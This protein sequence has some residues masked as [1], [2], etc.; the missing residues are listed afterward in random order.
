MVIFAAAS[1]EGEYL[2]S[3]QSELN[4]QNASRDRDRTRQE[5]NYSDM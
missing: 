3:S 4:L 2:Q 5:T 1:I